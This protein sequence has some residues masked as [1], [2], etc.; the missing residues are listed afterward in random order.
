MTLVCIVSGFNMA[1]MS[2]AN[3]TSDYGFSDVVTDHMK[4]IGRLFYIHSP[5]ETLYEKSEDVPN[6]FRQVRY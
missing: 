3:A 2:L 4:G 6:F 5:Q 1:D